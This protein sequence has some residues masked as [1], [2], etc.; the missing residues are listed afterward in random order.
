MLMRTCPHYHLDLMSGF[1]DGKSRFLLSIGPSV[2]ASCYNSL[3]Q[4][5]HG[6]FD[7]IGSIL[8]SRFKVLLEN[9]EGCVC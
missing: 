1:Q 6:G 4:R 7:N 5:R 9:H 8:Q 3:K 2:M